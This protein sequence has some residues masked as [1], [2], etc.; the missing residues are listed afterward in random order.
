M[1]QI[2]VLKD[3]QVSEVGAYKD[4]LQNDGSFA[5][6]LRTYMNEASSDEESDP[7][8]LYS[9][10]QTKYDIMCREHLDIVFGLR[11]TTQKQIYVA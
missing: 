9:K 11:A 6:F 4:L 7:E 1:D 10:H 2:I 5:D 3:G 8:G